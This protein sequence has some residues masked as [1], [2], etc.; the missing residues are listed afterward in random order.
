MLHQLISHLRRNNTHTNE[1]NGHNHL[2]NDSHSQ[3]HIR[4]PIQDPKGGIILEIRQNTIDGADS[5]ERN[6]RQHGKIDLGL[7]LGHAGEK[8]PGGARNGDEDDEGDEKKDGGGLEEFESARFVGGEFG[9]AV[10]AEDEAKKA[11][12]V[13]KLEDADAEGLGLDEVVTV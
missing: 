9:A 13:G 7:A 3:L 2:L 1:H 6:G 10:D 4:I 12:E 11:G 8:G 5:E